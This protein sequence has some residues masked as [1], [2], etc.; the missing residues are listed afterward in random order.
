MDLR[1]LRYFLHVASEGN[2]ALAARRLSVAPS[3]LY[4]RLK[5]LEL[6]LGITL[7]DH[8]DGNVRLSSSGKL[9][10]IH[11][12]RIVNEA[13]FIREDMASL[14]KGRDGVVRI[15]ANNVAT[16][17]PAIWK[18]IRSARSALPQLE[19]RLVNC[20]SQEQIR[21]IRQGRLDLGLVYTRTDADPVAFTSIQHQHFIL[22][23]PH[24]H[25][26]A[27]ADKVYLADL[28][29]EDFIFQIRG[30]YGTVHDRLIAAC[31]R[32]GLVPYIRHYIV[33][34]DTQLAMVAAGMGI[35]L[36]MEGAATRRWRKQ[37]VFK[38]VEDLDFSLDLDLIW[39]QELLSEHARSLIAA[40]K[41]STGLGIFKPSVIA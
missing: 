29:G 9:F 39:N 3:T 6:D 13:T 10:L 23:V 15:G 1:H 38:P 35:S 11:A 33:Q 21:R 24:D 37:I 18:A 5:D 31:Q 19:I 30:E 8:Q 40:I 17:L 7:F 27:S 12:Q 34:E 41:N 20:Q 28:R 22:V 2:F 4:R 32:G 16:E 26:L 36:T 25:R 14:A